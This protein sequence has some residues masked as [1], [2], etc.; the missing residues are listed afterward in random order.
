MTAVSTRVR[1]RHSSDEVWP[2]PFYASPMVDSYDI[3][4]RCVVDSVFGHLAG[5]DGLVAAAHA[6][7]LR[8]LVGL[9]PNH[10]SHRHP[11]FVRAG[12]AGGGTGTCG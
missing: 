12:S 10:T 4:G 7:G 3:T 8:V 5:F 1:D 9:G 6:R 2:S 11:W